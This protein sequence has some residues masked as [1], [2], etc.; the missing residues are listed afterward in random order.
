MNYNKLVNFFSNKKLLNLLIL[1]VYYLLVVLP[2]EWVGLL[3]VKIFGDLER[4]T[5][6]L[7]VLYISLTFLTI[8][9]IT[10]A[11][12]TLRHPQKKIILFY[13][14]STI[15]FAALCFNILF[16]VN[17]EVVHFFQYALF[18]LLCYPLTLN[19][20]QTLLISTLAGALDEAYQYF[21]LS[22]KRTDYFDF[23][24]VVI[25]LIGVA[26][27][28]II[29]KIFKPVTKT[30]QLKQF[31]KSP[32]F[33]LLFAFSVII[34]IAFNTNILGVYHTNTKAQFLLVKK[35]FNSFWTTVHPNITYH[36]MLP[37]EGLLVTIALWL[38]YWPLGK[39]HILKK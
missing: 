38:F 37:L 18:V 11:K 26:L 17:I 8:L 27:G 28:L 6:N 3:T 34:L 14:L 9:I 33:I 23:N 24:D 2:H 25:N 31:F 22:P 36:V 16:V 5:Y 1:F 21:Y 15:F 20:N 4:S 29:I 30:I 10:L 13:V 7:I 12:K 19:Y 39:E 35:S 32:A